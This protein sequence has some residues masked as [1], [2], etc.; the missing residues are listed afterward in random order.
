[1]AE[2]IDNKLKDNKQGLSFFKSGTGTGKTLGFCEYIASS[3]NSGKGLRFAVL[4]PTMNDVNNIYL[5]LVG[6]LDNPDLCVP[7]S[8]AHDSQKNSFEKTFVPAITSRKEDLEKAQVIVLTHSFGF[9]SDIKVLDRYIGHRDLV[10]VDEI[11]DKNDTIQISLAT[12]ASAKDRS[13]EHTSE[14][15]SQAYLVCRLLLEKKNKPKEIFTKK[16]KEVTHW[17]DDVVSNT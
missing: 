17:T 15:Q 3:V 4:V 10:L 1:M 13:E 9:K 16:S 6:L 11:P 12:F 14:L 2:A 7:W 5:H 8:S